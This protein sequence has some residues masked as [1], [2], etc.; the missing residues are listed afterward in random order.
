MIGETPEW[1]VWALPALAILIS[2]DIAR[3]FEKL[4]DYPGV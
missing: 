2:E 1:A 4:H 3:N